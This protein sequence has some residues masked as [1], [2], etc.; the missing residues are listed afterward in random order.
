MRA[1]AGEEGAGQ[2]E[3][4]RSV[5]A[6][7]AGYFMR[8]KKCPRVSAADGGCGE[9]PWDWGPEGII[10]RPS[11][12]RGFSRGLIGPD[13]LVSTLKISIGAVFRTST[14]DALR[15]NIWNGAS[16]TLISVDPSYIYCHHI[17]FHDR[18]NYKL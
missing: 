6:P 4:R 9:S 17:I 3:R 11:Y 5:E 7:L 2:E 10:W 12:F 13:F 15:E 8:K 14:G 1:S 18:K 16:A